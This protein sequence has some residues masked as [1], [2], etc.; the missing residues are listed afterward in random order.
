M[1]PATP[2]E[3]NHRL[4][5]ECAGI[6]GS[7]LKVMKELLLRVKGSAGSAAKNGVCSV[8]PAVGGPPFQRWGSRTWFEFVFPTSKDMGHPAGF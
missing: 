2:A 3:A 8:V 6:Y 5:L 7:G 1:N 4:G